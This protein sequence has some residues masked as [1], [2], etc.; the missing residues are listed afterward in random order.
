MS[1]FEAW[2]R[3]TV[4]NAPVMWLI[5][6][7]DRKH[8][9]PVHLPLPVPLCS[10]LSCCAAPGTACLGS[11][12]L[13]AAEAAAGPQHAE[14]FWN[15]SKKGEQQARGGLYVRVKLAL[16]DVCKAFVKC[17]RVCRGRNLFPILFQWSDS[18]FM[19]VAA[20]IPELLW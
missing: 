11:P 19:A 3:L 4:V 17:S 18:V 1:S 8:S 15:C 10:S 7:E 14:R 6:Q 9:L 5:S 2:C 13:P 20:G 12:R 16:R